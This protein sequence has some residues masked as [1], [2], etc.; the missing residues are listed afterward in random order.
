LWVALKAGQ[1]DAILQD[2]PVN[3]EHEVTDAAYKIVETYNTNE[4]YGFAFAK[5]KKPEL[6]A[7]VNA[8]LKAMRADGSYDAIYKKYFG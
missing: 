7:A 2:Q 8:Q 3:H 5:G 6:L 1:I 4:Q